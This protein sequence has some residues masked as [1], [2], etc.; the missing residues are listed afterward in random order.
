MPQPYMCRTHNGTSQRDWRKT[1]I[2][3][4]V[5][6]SHKLDFW[7]E[8]HFILITT[9]KCELDNGLTKHGYG[10]MWWDH[11]G[12]PTY[13]TCIKKRIPNIDVSI[14]VNVNM[15]PQHRPMIITCH[16]A[17]IICQHVIGF[18]DVSSFTWNTWPY[19]LLNWIWNGKR[20]RK[21]N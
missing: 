6:Y 19:I 20:N 18:H 4:L 5:R 10:T 12:S 11:G 13:C 16:W 9:S 2:I 15:F 21:L 3:N 14:D 7:R 17:R 8:T 1:F